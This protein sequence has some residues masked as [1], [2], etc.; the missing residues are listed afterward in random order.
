MAAATVPQ[1]RI[2]ICGLSTEH[3]LD[4]AL[5]LGVDWIGL[6]HFPR[7]PRHVD[8]NRAAALSSRAKGRAERVVLLVDPDDMLLADAIAAVDP[9]LIQLHG[10]ESPERV[11]A[12]RALTRRPVMKALG[13][14]APADLA[15]LIAYAAVADRIL[16]DAKAPA[17][18][19]LP[20]GNGRRFDWT[21]LAGRYLP[22]D[23]MLSGG[24]DAANVA[25]ALAR[26]QLGA[27]DVSSG[28]E[29]APGIKDPERIA[30]FVAAARKT[31]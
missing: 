29:A 8:L 28:V 16:L 21:I 27:V 6:V 4:A 24:L 19:A 3:T 1:A 30:A 26:T 25:E 12:I 17:D 20:G 10:Q 15:P 14:A 2:K 13:L 18:A 22:Q 7:S 23:T 31:R 9:D 5:A 11:A